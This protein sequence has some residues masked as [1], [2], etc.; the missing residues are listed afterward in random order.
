M[1]VLAIKRIELCLDLLA[2]S[3]NSRKFEDKVLLGIFFSSNPGSLSPEELYK[4]NVPGDKFL[5]LHFHLAESH[6]HFILSREEGGGKTRK[7]SSPH[8][9]KKLNFPF[10]DVSSR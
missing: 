7:T 1:L 3:S 10:C 4:I 5:I 8:G 9:K 6:Q 2:Q